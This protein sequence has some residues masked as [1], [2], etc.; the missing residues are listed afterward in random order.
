MVED[1]VGCPAGPVI[2]DGLTHLRKEIVATVFP[3]RLDH[4]AKRFPQIC[5]RLHAAPHCGQ[6]Q[7]NPDW[8][9][10]CRYLGREGGVEPVGPRIVERQPH[11]HARPH[12]ERHLLDGRIEPKTTILWQIF[13]QLVK[14][15]LHFIAVGV[16]RILS[17]RGLHDPAVPAMI[18]KVAQHQPS[19]KE[20]MKH[21]PSVV[22]R[23]QVVGVTQD[24]FERVSGA[25]GD[26]PL[27]NDIY[28]VDRAERLDR[29]QVQA[30]RIPQEIERVADNGRGRQMGDMSEGFVCRH[31]CLDWLQ[32]QPN[33]IN[34]LAQELNWVGGD[35]VSRRRYRVIYSAAS[36]T[37]SSCSARNRSASSA[38]MQ[39]IPAEVTACRYL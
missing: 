7:R 4:V 39:P 26:A 15:P 21:V 19:G 36:A 24:E 16:Q 25:K 37:V 30:Q 8:C 35:G 6:G 23:K 2:I 27:A 13:D 5:S 33:G 32:S 34:D 18:V 3:P 20:A 14:G 22:A 17:K 1:F 12:F 9:N 11:E 28:L 38:A 10:G 29:P 31:G